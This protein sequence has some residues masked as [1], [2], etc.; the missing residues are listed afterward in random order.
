MPR[1]PAWHRSDE[2]A[3]G[4]RRPA[5]GPGVGDEASGAT[6]GTLRRAKA[7]R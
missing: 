7:L 1:V 6:R 2:T 4:G 5:R 3:R